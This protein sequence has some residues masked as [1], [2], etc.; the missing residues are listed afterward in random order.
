[1]TVFFLL[2]DPTLAYN[3]SFCVA[4]HIVTK[5]GVISD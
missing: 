2:G 3:S 4:A 1:M 5:V